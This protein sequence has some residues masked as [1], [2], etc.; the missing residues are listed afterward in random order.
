[1]IQNG[2]LSIKA[3]LCFESFHEQSLCTIPPF[4][5]RYVAGLDGL[6]RL[7]TVRL[8]DDTIVTPEVS[9]FV[10]TSYQAQAEEGEENS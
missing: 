5:Y 6:K 10:G 9:T 1:M 7:Q 4:I 2:L 8:D 3:Q